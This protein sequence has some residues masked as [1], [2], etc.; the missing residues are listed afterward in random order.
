MD[1][2]EEMNETPGKSSG[3]KRLKD[4]MDIQYTRIAIYV[5]ITACVLF[6]LFRIIRNFE[7][8]LQAIGAGMHWLGV[9]LTPLIAGFILAYIVSPLVKFFERRLKKLPLFKKREK[10]P[11]GTAVLLAVGLIVIALVL[12]LSVIFSMLSRQFRLFRFDDLGNLISDFG[13]GV[14]KMTSDLEAWVKSLNIKSADLSKFA[15]SVTNWLQNASQ[16]LANSAVDL[17]G[18]L[19]TILANAVFAIIFGIYFL[20]DADGLSRYWNRV[21]KAVSN[22]KTYDRFHILKNDADKVFSGYIRGQLL[23]AIFVG[24]IVSVVLSLLGVD[25]AVVIGVFTGLGNLI[26]Y[27]GPVIAYVSTGIVCLMNQDVQKMVISIIVLFIIMTIDGN[28]IE[29]KLVGSSIDIHPMLVIVALLIGGGIGGL[30]GMLFAVPV[31]ALLKMQFDKVIDTILRK[32]EEAGQK[33]KQK[34][35]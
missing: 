35:G 33:E 23:D 27:V 19:P 15:E 11:R 24:V 21:L 22:Q 4:R 5:V 17:L 9:I 20:L 16:G 28:V 12:G 18:G 29:P 30:L 25:F 6:I 3:M 13:A 26:P 8:V 7:A 32:K 34:T 14:K 1:K 10:D 31:A 2:K